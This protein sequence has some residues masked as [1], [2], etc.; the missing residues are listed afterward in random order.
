MFE[1]LMAKSE[2]KGNVSCVIWLRSSLFTAKPLAPDQRGLRL[3]K[4]TFEGDNS[5]PDVLNLRLEELNDI[6]LR[7]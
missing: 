4:P 5:C 2:L 1:S 3:Q 7:V 6:V